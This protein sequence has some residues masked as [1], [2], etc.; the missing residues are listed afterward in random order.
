[1]SD[2]VNPDHYKRGPVEAI[3]VLRHVT[4]WRLGNAM[5][6]TW[7]VAFGGKGNDREDIEK[8]IWYLNDWLHGTAKGNSL[9]YCLRCGR[10][11]GGGECGRDA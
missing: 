6:Y 5:K 1:M 7:R 2:A 9:Q 3:E 10:P 8:A 11:H 4:D